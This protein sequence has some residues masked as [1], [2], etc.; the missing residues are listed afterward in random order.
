[1]QVEKFVKRHLSY[2]FSL[3]AMLLFNVSTYGQTNCVPIFSAPTTDVTRTNAS[4][5]NANDGKFRIN[6]NKLKGTA[7]YKYTVNGQSLNSDSLENLATGV[8]TV[9][10][11]DALGC[12]DSIKVSILDGNG[13]TFANNTFSPAAIDC[14]TFTGQIITGDLQPASLGPFTY[15][16][17]N[18]PA[19][20]SNVFNGLASG[21]YSVTIFYGPGGSCKFVNDNVYVSNKVTSASGCSAG[22]DI[23]IFEG[24]SAFINGFGD[25][26]ISWSPTAFLSDP[27]SAS[28][29]ASPPIGINTFTMTSY[30]SS[31]CTS[32]TDEVDITVIPELDIPNTFTPNGDDVNDVWVIGGLERFDECEMWIYTRWGQ[33]VFHQNGYEKGEEWNGTNQGLPLPAATY[34]YVLDI[35]RKDTAS[36]P[37]K[38]AG[39]IN[40]VK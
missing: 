9:V 36:Q 18:G 15:S 34:Y 6:T 24:E 22:D 11:V 39:A 14:N 32:C 26:V 19:Q 23:T 35:K 25:G 7:P 4:L 1:M 37:K 28:P 31:S 13:M 17:N 30:N 2:L 33:R 20:V 8:Y 16:L 3:M 27:T 40:I 10:A 5:C 12:R 38:Y 21:K 29:F